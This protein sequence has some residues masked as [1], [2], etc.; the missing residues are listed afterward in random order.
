[1]KLGYVCT[2]FNSSEVTLH[3]VRTL[4]ANAGHDIHVAVVDNQSRP[5]EVTKL[6]AIEGPGVDVLRLEKNLGYFGG[7]NAGIHHLRSV[8][9]DIGWIIAGNNDLEFSP[10]F[11][12]RLE[13]IEPEIRQHPVVSPD[14]ITGDNEHQNPHVL[15]KISKVREVF[16]DLY[17]S[18]YYLGLLIHKVALALH[19]FTD[20]CDEEN[21]ETPGYIYQGH[22][23]VYL[24]GPRFFELFSELWAP[25]FI[26][27]EEYFLSR[28]LADAG[29]K[30]WYDPRLQVRHLWHASLAT[31]PSKRRWEYARDAHK[32][33]RQYVKVSPFA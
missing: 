3:A 17:Y 16:Y 9:P 27:S 2:N 14:I 25:T 29:E 4:L 33:Y 32:V 13:A 31:L 10:D 8:R 12:D 20:R 5:E 15:E 24:I 7:L 11:C 26:M 19:R 30:V 21:W 1:M 28:Q 23:S 18:N 22:G 6:S